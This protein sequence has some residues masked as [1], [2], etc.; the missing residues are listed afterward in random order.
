MYTSIEVGFPGIGIDKFDISRVAFYIGD[1]PIMWY[2]IIITLGM[3][4]AFGYVC[5]KTREY[6]GIKADDCIDFA[7]CI[8]ISGIIGARLYY[9]ITSDSHYTFAEVFKI[10]NG[11]LAIYGGI[12]AGGL[13]AVVM[14]LIK[15]IRPQ[16]FCDML[17]PAVMI[18]QSI[19]RWGNFFNGEAHGGETLSFLRMELYHVYPSGN[20]SYVG[21]VHPTFLYESLW[22]LLGFILLN[23]MYRRRRFDGQVVLSYFIWYGFGRMFIEGLR[24]DSLYVGSF[25]ISQ[26]VGLLSCIIA[27]VAMVVFWKKGKIYK[28]ASY[29]DEP[30]DG[31]IIARIFGEAEQAEPQADSSSTLFAAQGSECV[32]KDAEEAEIFENIENTE[33]DEIKDDNKS[34][35]EK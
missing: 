6:Q 33:N 28:S 25:R 15:K 18:A 29:K 21:C 4:L 17:A 34:E 22:N 2:G 13:A 26:V 10:W 11:G 9:V 14:C 23:V 31:G 35:G 12:I 20:T 7:M 5:L 8:L 27:A 32:I 3:A 1:H 30:K 24:T 19:G 16:C